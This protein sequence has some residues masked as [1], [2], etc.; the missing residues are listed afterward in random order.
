MYRCYRC[1]SILSM[2]LAM[3]KAPAERLYRCS[4]GNRASA[5]GPVPELP[6][7]HRTDARLHVCLL[8][9]RPELEL[10]PSAGSARPGVGVSDEE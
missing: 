8:G 9:E 10:E 6:G 7:C 5:S 3:C 1:M 2:L 4:R